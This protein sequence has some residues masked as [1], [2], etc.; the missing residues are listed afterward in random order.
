MAIG[1]DRVQVT[2][3]ESTALG[4]K[5]DD[6]SAYGSP[7]PINPQEDAIE[8]AGGYVQDASNRDENVGWEREGE[9]LKFFDQHVASTTLTAFLGCHPFEVASGKVLK[10]PQNLQFDHLGRFTV[11]GRLV[12]DGRFVLGIGV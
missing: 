4:G 7:A 5:D 2:K 12:I 6:I 11:G 1:P 9:D 3:V 8:T 10:I